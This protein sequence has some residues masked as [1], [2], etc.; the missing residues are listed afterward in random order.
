M[1][2]ISDEQLE[3][4]LDWLSASKHPF[5]LKMISALTE[6]RDLRVEMQEMIDLAGEAIGTDP[7]LRSSACVK[8]LCDHVATLR[9]ELSRLRASDKAP[10][11]SVQEQWCGN[12][13]AIPDFAQ[14]QVDS[15]GK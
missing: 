9:K 12:E 10:K 13:G 7:S 3:S 1:D 8:V 11:K 15:W 5:D 6:L 4:S 2:R 14:R